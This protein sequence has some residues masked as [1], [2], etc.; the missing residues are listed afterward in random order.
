LGTH[1]PVPEESESVTQAVLE[2][3]FL[4][5][6]HRGAG[7]QL[8]LDLG[9]PQ[10]AELHRRWERD[11]ERERINRT[12]FAQRALKPEEVQRELEATD[13]VLGDPAA[14]REFVLAA[15]QRIG[16]PI[17]RESKRDGIY[18]ISLDSSVLAT[19]PDVIR[20]S[21]AHRSPLATRQSPKPW[22]ISFDSPTP[23]GAEYVGR[24]H[25]FVATLARFLFEEALSRPGS[26]A[27]SR[28][29]ALRTRAVEALTT[30]LLLRVRYL[31][32]QPQVRPLLSEEVLV[33]GFAEG[34]P[35]DAEW[36]E[37]GEALRLLAEAKPDANIPMAEKRELVERAVATLGDWEGTTGDWGLRHPIQRAI[38]ERMARRASELTDA[39][40]RIRQAVS[41]RVRGLEVKSQFPPDLLGLLVLQP[42]VLR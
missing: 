42:L 11:V 4:R 10:V 23:E 2:A 27:V 6:G 40:K 26:A 20:L 37:A 14:V 33:V 41:L 19:L 17:A 32:E 25:R 1:V 5:G 38:R 28:C 18:R 22:L 9:I 3:L 34:G 30:I 7:R 21:L 16:L 15:A 24:N 12:R 13:A 35:R 39:H 31:V 29:G 8:V 36:L